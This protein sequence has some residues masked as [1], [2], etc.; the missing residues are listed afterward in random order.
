[1]QSFRII[2]LITS[3]LTPSITTWLTLYLTHDALTTLTVLIILC[4]ITSI[5]LYSEKVDAFHWQYYLEKEK[6][7]AKNTLVQSVLTFVITSLLTGYILILFSFHYKSPFLEKIALP[8]PFHDSHTDTLYWMI[9][10]LIF[11]LV[12]PVSEEMYYRI[13]QTAN[14]EGLLSELMLSLS[15][16]LMHFS[17]IYWVFTGNLFIWLWLLGAFLYAFLGYQ[18]HKWFGVY[19]IFSMRVG[20]AVGIGSWLLYIG[21]S[22]Y[23]GKKFYQPADFILGHKENIFV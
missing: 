23:N 19:V 14:W 22:F 4:Y 2:F 10:G 8:F 11:C 7:R 1:M 6:T 18:V 17:C 20:F 16:T 21:V 15:Y 5:F 9:F 3:L 12:L 13:F